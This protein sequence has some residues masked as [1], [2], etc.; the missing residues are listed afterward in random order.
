MSGEQISRLQFW[1][2][3]NI[4][5]PKEA[6]FGDFLQVG[7]ISRE[8]LLVA[9]REQERLGESRILRGVMGK[10]KNGSSRPRESRRRPETG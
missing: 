4:E 2:H 7:A 10:W 1:P 6:D 9:A 5:V 8:V 3:P